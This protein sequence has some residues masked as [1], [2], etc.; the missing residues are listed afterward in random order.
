MRK[1]RR[2]LT[3]AELKFAAKNKKPVYYI[4][5]Y[6]NPIDKHMEFKGKCVM[7]EA[8]EGYYIGNSDIIPDDFDNK[9][10]V[11]GEFPEGVFSVHSVSGVRYKGK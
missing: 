7:K 9:D 5:C 1:E 11:R 8:Q 6:H 4:E 2:V 3:G 10:L